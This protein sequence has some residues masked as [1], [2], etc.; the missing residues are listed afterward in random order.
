METND[1][2][3]LLLLKLVDIWSSH[4][5]TIHILIEN[6]QQSVQLI[7]KFTLHSEMNI[8]MITLNSQ[9]PSFNLR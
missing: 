4:D 2:I 6:A 1:K 9:N 3:H 7:I 5:Y 8:L